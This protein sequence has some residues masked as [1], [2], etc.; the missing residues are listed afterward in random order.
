MNF[1]VLDHKGLVVAHFKFWFDATLYCQTTGFTLVP[2][3][4]PHSPA[5]LVG[6][7]YKA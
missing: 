1:V 4:L 7:T 5:P 3:N 2:M 6:S